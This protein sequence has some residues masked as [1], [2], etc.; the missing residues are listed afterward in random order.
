MKSTKVVHLPLWALS[1]SCKLV[2][3]I[4]EYID[5]YTW[6]NLAKWVLIAFGSR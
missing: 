5:R 2:P 1:L 6:M 3:G 4:W